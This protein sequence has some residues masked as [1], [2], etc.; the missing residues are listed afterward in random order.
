MASSTRASRSARRHSPSDVDL[1]AGQSDTYVVTVAFTIDGAATLEVRDCTG[2]PGSGAY[3][4]VS[5]TVNGDAGDPA[6]ACI[7]LP[8]PII[9]IEKEASDGQPVLVAANVYTAE[10][11]ITVDNVGGGPGAYDLADMP[12]FGAGATVTNIAVTGNGVAIDEATAGPVTIITGETIDPDEAAHVYTVTVTFEVDGAMTTDARTCNGEPGSGAFNGGAVTYNGDQTAQDDDC[13]DIPEPDVTIDKTLDAENP[14]TRNAD[15][16]WSLGYL[17]VAANGA[18]AG[19]ADYDLDD[20]FSFTSGVTVDSVT[21]E[22]VESSAVEGDLIPGFDGDAQPSI[23]DGVQVN[24]GETHTYRVLVELS[25]DPDQG[26]NGD[27]TTEGGLFN[28]MSL[29]VRGDDP[30]T[31]DACASF[32]VL[33]L[34]K[35]LV[36]DD[37]GNAELDDFTLTAE[38]AAATISG[39]SPVVSAVP[40]GTYALG[41]TQIDGYGDRRLRLRRR[42]ARRHHGGGVRGCERDLH[43]HE[44]RHPGRPRSSPRTTAASK[45]SPVGT[46]SRTPSR[47]RTWAAVTPTSA[48][49]SP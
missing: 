29:S 5:I 44:R 42:R 25:I 3:N 1:P 37:G 23:V 28:E 41:E 24:A 12:D 15:G 38:S 6:D 30:L 2:E 13:V 36:N 48:S 49:R 27:C 43:D 34:V 18:D 4:S 31:D 46:R 40:A 21:V 11:T 9:T 10:Y 22:I 35:V 16:I 19:P 7:E 20:T 17:L 39:T 32:S 47:S 26:T 8:D 14:L 45:P 33:T